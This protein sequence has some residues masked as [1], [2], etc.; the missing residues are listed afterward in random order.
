[1][2]YKIVYDSSSDLRTND[3][4]VSVPLKII[5]SEREFVDDANLDVKEMVEY[6]STYK[7]KSSTS[8]PNINDWLEAFG[9]AENVFCIAITSKLSGSFNSGHMACEEY[10]TLHPGRRAHVFDSTSTGAH[11]ELIGDKIEELVSQGLSFDEIITKVDEY[12]LKLRTIFSLECLNNLANNGRVSKVVATGANIFGI[13]IV[14]YATNGQ[15]DP[16]FKV[17]GEKRAIAKIMEMLKDNNY[18]GGK[19]YINTCF[20]EKAAASLAQQVKEIYG[21]DAKINSCK[22]LDSFYAEKGG[23]I[24]AFEME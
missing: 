5:T 4:I 19:I 15:L 2:N 21:A 17:K 16:Q 6:L 12:A 24:L 13:R 8:C 20:N 3:K 18:N 9:D 7:G 10:E 11:L 14:G 23:I 22:G 1:M